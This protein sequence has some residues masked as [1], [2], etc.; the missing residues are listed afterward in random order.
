MGLCPNFPQIPCLTDFEINLIISGSKV[1]LI[2]NVWTFTS[3]WIQTDLV[4]LL[5]QFHDLIEV[6]LAPLLLRLPVQLESPHLQLQL[7]T[8]R[9][10]LQI[11]SKGSL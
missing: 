6:G 2:L 4:P 5:L 10:Q 1:S 7:L 3:G 8:L 9:L 11:Q